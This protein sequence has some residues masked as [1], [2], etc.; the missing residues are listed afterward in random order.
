MISIPLPATTPRRKAAKR[1]SAIGVSN[2]VV[3]LVK[4]R[5]SDPLDQGM[6]SAIIS[7][8]SPPLPCRGALGAVDRHPDDG[9][10]ETK[11]E[12]GVTNCIGFTLTCSSAGPG[13]A[14]HV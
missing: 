7:Q 6:F 9:T 13:C 12:G 4:H 1:A 11:G 2:I 5:S 3:L 8:T 14:R 10:G